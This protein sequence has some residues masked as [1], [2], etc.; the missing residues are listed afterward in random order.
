MWPQHSDSSVSTKQLTKSFGWDTY[1]TF[2]QHDVQELNRVLV[3]KLEEKMKGT[4]VEGTMAH[5][6]RGKFTNY[7]S[8]TNVDDTSLRD[9]EFYDLQLVVKGCK[10]RMRA[11]PLPSLPPRRPPAFLFSP[12]PPLPI[13]SPSHNRICMPRSTTT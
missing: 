9:E 2:M 7:V 8:C 12:V 3:D 5:L 11:A 13:P 10:V 6:F 1:D 4:S